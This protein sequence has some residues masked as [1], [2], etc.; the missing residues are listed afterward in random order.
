MKL[1][2]IASF[3]VTS[4]AFALSIPG[5]PEGGLL[6]KRK[7]PDPP[8]SEP[9]VVKKV[10][11]RP[12]PQEQVT[13]PV[14]PVP[15]P[16]PQ[17]ESSPRQ[18]EPVPQRESPPRQPEPAPQ[19]EL[20]PPN[21]ENRPQ[22][23]RPAPRKCTNVSCAQ[24]QCS[25]CNDCSQG[26]QNARP[27]DREPRPVPPLP[28]STGGSCP[29]SPDGGPCPVPQYVPP[30]AT[31]EDPSRFPCVDGA[32]MCSLEPQPCAGGNPCPPP[33][34]PMP[35]R[36]RPQ[37]R[38]R[39]SCPNGPNTCPPEN[40][41]SCAGGNSGGSGCPQNQTPPPTD[42]KKCSNSG[43]GDIPT[44]P[45]PVVPGKARGQ[46]CPSDGNSCP[47]QPSKGQAEPGQLDEYPREQP[48]AI[49]RAMEPPN[50][51]SGGNVMD[52]KGNQPQPGQAQAQ[53]E[54]QRRVTW[55]NSQNKKEIIAS[56]NSQ[57]KDFLASEQR[58]DAYYQ[59]LYDQG[60]AKRQEQVQHEQQQKQQQQPK[61][62][63]QAEA[64]AQNNQQFDVSSLRNAVQENHAKY[65]GQPPPG[66][67]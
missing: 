16:V 1:S 43:G 29:E 9:P 59:R 10:E 22:P 61:P 19:R 23:S 30:Q 34:P 12:K 66:V 13:E 8:Q 38:P 5:A 4:T 6:V 28:P 35:R 63:V 57:S 44:C 48:P 52:G 42:R 46:N 26:C 37:E 58:S 54:S 47:Q 50:Q 25:E 20:P 31:P 64:P 3:L 18:P 7:D 17:R 56:E 53:G 41:Q 45:R 15:E 51:H 27:I 21:E 40:Q 33:E 11:I 36:P 32:G 2:I 24:Q 67:A 14:A 49:H 39:P 55:E 60:E 62:Q 65:K